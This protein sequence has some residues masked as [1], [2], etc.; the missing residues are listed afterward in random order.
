M[1]LSWKKGPG[2]WKPAFNLSTE[3][4]FG[5]SERAC[6]GEQ[7]WLGRGKVGRLGDRRTVTTKKLKEDGRHLRAVGVAAAVAYH[8]SKG[9]QGEALNEPCRA[10]VAAL[11]WGKRLPWQRDL[12]CMRGSL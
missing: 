4:T 6:A 2:E 11:Q 5:V 12:E 1:S 9:N 7:S 3:A 8:P 10:K